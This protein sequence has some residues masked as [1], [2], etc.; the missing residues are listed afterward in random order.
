LEDKSQETRCKQKNTNKNPNK[1]SIGTPLERYFGTMLPLCCRT[2]PIDFGNDP[3]I[4]KELI[5]ADCHAETLIQKIG[6]DF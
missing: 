4:V 1:N 3:S 2:E 6:I 5:L